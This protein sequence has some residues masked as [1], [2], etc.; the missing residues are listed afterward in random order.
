[1]ENSIILK[2]QTNLVLSGVDKVQNISPTE[3]IVEFS[4]KKLVILG[5][6][7]EVEA[8]EPQ[9]KELVAKGLFTSFKFAG[10]KQKLLKRLFK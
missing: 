7:I 4:G 2:N 3:I 8:L 5:E 9:S 10:E 6:N 1:M